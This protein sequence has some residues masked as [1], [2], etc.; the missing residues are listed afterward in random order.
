MFEQFNIRPF[1]IPIGSCICLIC[2]AIVYIFLQSNENPINSDNW[3][4]PIIPHPQ[5]IRLKNDTQPFVINSQTRIAFSHQVD[6]EDSILIDQLKI[7]LNLQ[8]LELQTVSYPYQLSDDTNVIFLLTNNTDYDLIDQLLS[9]AGPQLTDNYPGPEGYILDISPK[10]IIV[11]GHDVEGR[12]YGL[13]SL[14]QLIEQGPQK[15]H[16][17]IRPVTIIDYPD[18]A[19]RSAFYGFY[20]NAL[21]DDAL[22]DRAYQD[23]KKIAQ[24][25]L[26]MIDLASH[27]YGHLE[28]TVPGQSQEK[29]WQRFAK[30]HEEARRNHLRPRVGGWAKWVNT[31]SPWGAD[32]TTLECIRTSQTIRLE[33]TN[34]YTLKISSGQSA[35]NV[36][37]DFAT[38][39]SWE[40]EPVIVTNEPSAMV[41][42][43]GKDYVVNFGKIG[44][45]GY[46]KHHNTSQ[47]HLEVLFN[48]VHYGEGEP[49]RYPLRWGDTFNLATTIQRIEEG[50]IQEGQQVKVTFSYIGPDPWSLIKVR[51]CRSDERL[52]KDGPENYLWR[53][54]TDPVRFG[55]ADD[56]SLDVD[57]TRVF[58]W[59]K[60]CLDSGKSRSAI[61]SD[62]IHYYYRTIRQANP[63]AR[64][65]MWSDM[66]D[67]AHNAGFKSNPGLHSD[68]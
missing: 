47:T 15:E 58:A 34:A 26:N 36:I 24:Y 51:Y 41:Y 13:Q 49:N 7:A 37:F 22:I 19:L 18:M 2:L 66:L 61:W 3:I 32:L 50:R 16:K 55:G 45:E 43:E 44:S 46:Q 8:V 6:P 4:L 38:G 12:F 42:E 63:N 48:K 60:R 53:W 59:D 57:E 28:M 65:S 27:H 35:P 40:K 56:F 10:C 23:F 5:E 68:A 9:P 33:G 31:K 29:L 30:L 14:I 67:P 11:A 62:D 52:H 17:Y 21:E 25:K 20:L 64:I 1:Y 39:K 54:C